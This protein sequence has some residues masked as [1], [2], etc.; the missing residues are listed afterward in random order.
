MVLRGSVR[1]SN[2]F[3]SPAEPF[4]VRLPLAGPRGSE[5][6]VPVLMAFQLG[7]E[8]AG[9]VGYLVG[10]FLHA[11]AAA[12]ALP[13]PAEILLLIS[14]RIDVSVRAVVPGLSTAAGASFLLSGSL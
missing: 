6:D 4:S 3:G 5:I 2:P 13:L 8:A 10:L 12:V 9:E 7:L 14:P 11:I 1:V